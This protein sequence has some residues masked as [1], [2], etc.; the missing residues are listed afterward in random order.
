VKIVVV[1]GARPNFVKIAPLMREMRRRRGIE[2]ILVHTGQHY[3][4]N[5]SDDFFK[6]LEISAPDYNLG[7]GS[8]S[9]ATQ[10]AR[11][12]LA[13]E[14]VCAKERPDLV[15]VVGDVNSTLAGALTAK[16]LGIKVAHVEAG[17]RSFDRA[18]PE[19][20][21]RLLT[22][23][24]ADYLFVTE[25]SGLKN[26]RREGV[27]KEKVFFVGNVMI[28]TLVRNLG[29][30]RDSHFAGELGLR[31][32]GFVVVTLHRPT[33]VDSEVKLRGILRALGAVRRT[34]VWPVHPRTRANLARFGLLSAS[35]KNGNLHLIEPL[36]YMQFLSLVARAAAV[37]T[38]SGGIQE[39]TTYLKVPCLT[40]RENTE[41]PVTMTLGTNVLVGTDPRRIV[42]ALAAA[43]KAKRRS[44]IPPLWDGHAAE[45]IVSILL[46]EA[47]R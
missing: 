17:L 23:A 26:L 22:D 1:A 45:R 24:I 21:N 32:R 44:R 11:I 18:M 14:E 40:L 10:T 2:P 13:F 46:R 35:K 12:M 30:I 36:G 39:E 47:R 34:V 3:N 8:G 33:N 43:L 27:G 28:D 25:E 38:D 19:E 15:L 5:M 6:D 4:P 20:I 42:P 29:K 16:K 31:E 9:H 37:V 7:V 41:R